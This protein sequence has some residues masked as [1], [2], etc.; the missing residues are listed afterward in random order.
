MGSRLRVIIEI[1]R[2]T[3]ELVQHFAYRFSSHRRKGVA[4][5][6]IE[7]VWQSHSPVHSIYTFFVI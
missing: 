7:I 2:G 5:H 4:R 6:E 1:H 3:I